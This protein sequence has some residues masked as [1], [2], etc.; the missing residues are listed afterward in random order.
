MEDTGLSKE[1]LENALGYRIEKFEVKAGSNLGDGYTCALFGV[2]VWKV[3]E[4]ENPIS[5]VVK[6][7]PVNESRQEFLETGNI[8]KI[9]LGMYD[10]VIPALTKFQEI[11][12]EKE[13][14]PLPF[15][16]MIFGQYI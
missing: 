13:R 7:Y 16:P 4:P 8:F 15:A 2:D 5:I 9:E 1:F 6:C 14:V 10:T 11:L 3:A 12:P